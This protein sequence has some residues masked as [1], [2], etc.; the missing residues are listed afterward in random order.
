MGI[1]NALKKNKKEEH[2][3]EKHPVASAVAQEKQELK[4]S[5]A[6]KTPEKKLT[7]IKNRDEKAFYDAGAVLVKPL[8]SEKG[9][10]VGEFNQYL[11]EVV[12]GTTKIEI[13]KAIAQTFGV[14]PIRVRTLRRKGK[15]V[16][17]GRVAGTQKLRKKALVTLKKGDR[18]EAY[19]GV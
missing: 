6:K 10:Y 18:I 1:L 12:D 7:A 17:T 9:S 14:T 4:E 8:V 13:K 3:T 15:R 5:S 2:K 16:R 19:Q 11:F